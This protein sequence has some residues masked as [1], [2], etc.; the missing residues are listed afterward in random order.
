M[1][2]SRP[3]TSLG[4]PLVTPPANGPTR[5]TSRRKVLDRASRVKKARVTRSRATRVCRR[6]GAAYH[7]VMSA[8]GQRKM[9]QMWIAGRW[10]EC[11]VRQDPRAAEPHR[12]RGDWDRA[13]SGREDV[14]AAVGAARA[15][16]D[17]GPFPRWSGRERGALLYRVAEAI[18]AAGGGAGRGRHP[19][20]GQADRR[21]R[22]RRRRRREL[23]RVLR[24]AGRRRSTARR[25]SVP[26]N[27]LSLVLRE[28][29]GVVGQIIPWNYPL[30]MAAWKL[31]PALAAGCTVRAQAGRA[32][33]AIGAR[34]WRGSSR[35]WSCRRASSTS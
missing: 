6:R 11:A 30:L 35:R 12:R 20:H 1:R 27:A 32:D 25:S 5:P 8:N 13:R 3:W 2:S 21:G 17:E 33:A 19:Q 18:R 10:V 22:V 34:C 24:R 14:R 7:F 4:T 28:P 26:D 9:W 29:V 15:A 16:F 31:A 23:L